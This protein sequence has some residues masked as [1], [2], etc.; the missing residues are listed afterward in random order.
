MW[1]KGKVI[2]VLVYKCQTKYTA[3]VGNTIAASLRDMQ[4]CVPLMTIGISVVP[5]KVITKQPKH[6]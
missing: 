5:L 1:I 3:T 2:L 6:Q 4:I